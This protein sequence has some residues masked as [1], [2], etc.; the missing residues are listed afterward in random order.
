L[1]GNFAATTSPVGNR[2]EYTAEVN[3]CPRKLEKSILNPSSEIIGVELLDVLALLLRP[4]L[5][6]LRA[7][8]SHTSNSGSSFNPNPVIFSHRL[9][10]GVSVLP[11][12]LK[13]SFR[14]GGDFPPETG[15]PGGERNCPPAGELDKNNDNE[16]LDDTGLNFLSLFGICNFSN[17]SLDPEGGVMGSLSVVSPVKSSIARLETFLLDP[18]RKV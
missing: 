3:P 7:S 15:V 5:R 9:D 16:E 4:P 18:G 10:T 14:L 17:F 12:S 13:I 8:T 1:R 6:F 11:S 2:A